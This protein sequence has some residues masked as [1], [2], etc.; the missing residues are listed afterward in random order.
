MLPSPAQ[1]FSYCA[2]AHRESV[3]PSCVFRECDHGL[4]FVL[5]GRCRGTVTAWW[6]VD[7][8]VVR[9]LRVPM[10]FLGMALQLFCRFSQA[11]V[12]RADIECV[13]SGTGPALHYGNLLPAGHSRQTT[14]E[15]HGRRY[16]YSQ[17]RFQLHRGRGGRGG[18]GGTALALCEEGAAGGCLDEEA[19]VEQAGGAGFNS[20]VMGSYSAS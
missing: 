3:G 7:G 10:A 4:R 14:M 20:S 13:E 1:R 5:L 18:R 6:L 9:V 11:S 16:L 12:R 19:A 8:G 15:I 17:E 2:R